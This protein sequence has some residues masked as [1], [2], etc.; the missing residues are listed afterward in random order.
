MDRR[1]PRSSCGRRRLPRP[2]GDGPRY[3]IGSA[4]RRSA[5]PPTRGWTPVTGSVP[6][7][8]A[9]SPAHAGMDPRCFSPMTLFTGLPRPRGDGPS[10][11]VTSP[12]ITAAPPPTRGW[13]R[14]DVDGAARLDGSP[15]HA[16]MDP[17]R[18]RRC[19]SPRWL[20]RPRG[21]GPWT[22]RWSPARSWAPP[23]TRGWTLQRDVPGRAVAGSPAHAG[24]DPSS[25]P[26]AASCSWLPRPRGDG[27]REDGPIYAERRA[28]PPTRGWTARQRAGRAARHGSPAHAGMDRSAGRSRTA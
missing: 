14:A 12:S 18:C 2:R 8:T 25:T 4:S 3:A 5:P 27:P 24:M 15:A 26:M 23:P 13:T 1:P 11:L 19:R 6:T 17:S 28:P 9:G 22:S 21:D 10:R 7:A 20:P 16:G